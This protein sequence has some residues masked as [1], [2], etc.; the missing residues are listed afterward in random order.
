MLLGETVKK[1]LAFAEH[2]L[3]SGTNIWQSRAL[4][5]C[6]LTLNLELVFGGEGEQEKR[7]RVLSA[8]IYY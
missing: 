6:N 1:D 7:Q 2:L 4:N 3:D 8:P 5:L